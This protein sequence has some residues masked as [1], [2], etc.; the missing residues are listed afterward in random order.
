MLVI[1][2]FCDLN[3][4]NFLQVKHGIHCVRLLVRDCISIF[5]T[6]V[7]RIAAVDGGA[8]MSWFSNVL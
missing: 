2:I 3:D 5:Y 6:C 1:V 8:M 7:C 4:L